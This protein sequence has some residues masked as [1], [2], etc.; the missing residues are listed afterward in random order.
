MSG[1]DDNL[2][3]STQG[4]GEG[5]L[6]KSKDSHGP[7]DLKQLKKEA[8]TYYLLLTTYYLLLTTYYLLLTTYYLLLTTYCDT[9][10]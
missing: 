8:T 5:V 10:Y 6:T 3:S 1:D 2:H 7:R 9:Y 4:S